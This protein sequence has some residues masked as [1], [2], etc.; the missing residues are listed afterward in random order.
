MFVLAANRAAFGH[1]GRAVSPASGSRPCPICPRQAPM[2]TVERSL[3]TVRLGR[4][5]TSVRPNRVPP[6][7]GQVACHAG[8][9]LRLIEKNLFAVR[10]N[11]P[12]HRAREFCVWRGALPSLQES[13]LVASPERS[14]IRPSWFDVANAEQQSAATIERGPIQCD[15]RAEAAELVNDESP[16]TP[17]LVSRERVPPVRRRSVFPRRRSLSDL[18]RRCGYRIG[19]PSLSSVCAATARPRRSWQAVTRAILLR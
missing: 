19:L 8:P 9:I 6:A 2:E 10:S 17:Q 18:R 16:P 14:V 4:G 11:R 13:P 12:V 5:S 3:A 15:A 1:V 7:R